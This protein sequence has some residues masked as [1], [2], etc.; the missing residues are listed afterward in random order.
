MEP[1]TVQSN[2]VRARF[3]PSLLSIPDYRKALA[4]DTGRGSC[5]FAEWARADCEKA[6]GRC[7]GCGS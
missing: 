3:I 1:Q 2:S 7:T 6:C 4:L 5:R